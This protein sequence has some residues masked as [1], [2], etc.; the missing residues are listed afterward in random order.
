[1]LFFFYLFIWFMKIF[2]FFFCNL[3]NGVYVIISSFVRFKILLLLLDIIFVV[4]FIWNFVNWCLDYV[5]FC[6]LVDFGLYFVR[7]WIFFLNFFCVKLRYLISDELICRNL[8]FLNL[9]F[10]ILKWVDNVVFLLVLFIKRGF[11][12]LC[13]NFVGYEYLLLFL[14]EG[15]VVKRICLLGYGIN[16]VLKL[17]CSLINILIV[18][19]LMLWM[20]LKLV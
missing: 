16:V 5:I 17:F 18:I 13:F 12:F 2:N 10:L 8:W 15:V 7:I 3:R 19:L 1:M 14:V 6:L 9:K 11:I 20:K 4:L